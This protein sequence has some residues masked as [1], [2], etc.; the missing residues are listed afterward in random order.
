MEGH[1]STDV[2]TFQNARGDLNIEKKYK[3][4]QLF[5]HTIGLLSS[6]PFV[7]YEIKGPEVKEVTLVSNLLH[8]KEG[9]PYKQGFYHLK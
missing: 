6:R 1:D 5:Y 8:Y 7:L 9:G 4:D 3:S 2:P